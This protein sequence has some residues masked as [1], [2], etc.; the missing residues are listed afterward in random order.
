MSRPRRKDVILVM[1]CTIFGAATYT[2]FEI[3]ERLF[4]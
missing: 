2:F 1:K 3:F 4:T